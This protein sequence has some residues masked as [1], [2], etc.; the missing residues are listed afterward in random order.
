MSKGCHAEGGHLRVL[1][2]AHS[3]PQRHCV[4]QPRG[5]ASPSRGGA[6]WLVLS[7][8]ALF[9]FGIGRVFTI[10][11]AQSPNADASAIIASARE[12]LGGEKRLAAIKTFVISGRTRQ[13]Q[14][15]NLVPIEFEISCELPDKCVRRDEVPA[16]ESGL[17]ASGF[18]GDTLIQLPAPPTAPAPPAGV[19]G[20]GGPP[21]QL[22]T[23]RIN[24]VKQEFVRW[25]LGMF[26]ASFGSFPVTF[27][28]AGQAEAPQG[29]ADVLDV[30]GPGDYTAR[31]FVLKDSHLPIMLSWEAPALGSRGRSGDA[32][33]PK[34]FDSAQGRPVEY[35]LY[36]ADYRDVDGL[37]LPF[38]LRRAVGAD[39]TEETNIDRFRI[40]T[41]IDARKFAAQ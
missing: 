14:G 8:F 38:R 31:L 34:P 20:R 11:S 15:D 39:T 2:G 23:Q 37:K 9:V 17:T 22:S 24:T 16:R 35:R 36:Y 10:A 5:S 19:P 3:A 12:A 30:K 1:P 7:V 32:A 4:E 33:P 40:N 29:Q 18:S 25:W 28:P 6:P 26:A 41:R 21:P 13:V 27:T